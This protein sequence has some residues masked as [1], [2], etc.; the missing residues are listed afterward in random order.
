[1]VGVCPQDAEIEPPVQQARADV[2]LRRSLKMQCQAG[3]GAHPVQQDRVEQHREAARTGDAKR[4]HV[5]VVGSDPL[6]QGLLLG[7]R[8][9]P[10]AKTSSPA[11][12]RVK[13]LPCRLTS[14]W[15]T[16][17]SS[18]RRCCDTPGCVMFRRS[19]ARVKCPVSHSVVKVFSQ[20]AFS[21][22]VS[23]IC[24]DFHVD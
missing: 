15:P 16:C 17:F 1:M 22:R 13:P 5:S 6:A 10:R 3:R 2:D 23:T 4:A 11:S 8:D 12:V 19:A 24:Y 21:T 14:G 20:V 18:L 9:R 7:P